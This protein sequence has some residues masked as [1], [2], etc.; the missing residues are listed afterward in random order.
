MIII[1]A[2]ETIFR[3]LMGRQPAASKTF[4]QAPDPDRL[5]AKWNEIEQAETTPS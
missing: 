1:A 3:T 5:F 4:E 2:I